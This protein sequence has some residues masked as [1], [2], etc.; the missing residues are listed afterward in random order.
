MVGLK[1]HCKLMKEVRMA[2]IFER[3]EKLMAALD[4]APQVLIVP[5]ND[6][7]PDAIASAVTLK[8]LIEEM[9]NLPVRIA[10]RGIIGRAENRALVR[11]L[12]HPL[13]CVDELDLADNPAV[14]LMDTQPGTGNNPLPLDY[15]P[16]VVID[17]HP[18]RELTAQA[19]FS[20]ISP[21]VGACSTILVEY[22]RA[23]EMNPSEKLATALFYGIQSDTRGL[24]RGS[25]PE[26]VEAYFYLQ[27]LIDVGA[28][29]KIMNAQVPQDY[30]KSLVRTLEAVR[31]Y[32]RKILFAHLGLSDYPDM[33]AEMADIL[34][35][36]EG[37]QW[38]I[39]VNTYNEM[40]VL[41]I[42]TRDEKGG[43]EELARA[44]VC[45]DG[46]AGGHDMMAGGQI[47]LVGEPPAD[48]ADKL[49]L[50]I[51]EYFNIPLEE[52]GQPLV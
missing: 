45:S 33:A 10:Y 31:I 21:H 2:A 12:E 38:V 17:H 1:F 26:D 6:P 34:L 8:H 5:H 49:R 37:S 35:R 14:I 47:P 29:G 51:L 3:L 41:S 16:A 36:L 32:R 22:L 18:L 15:V 52:P 50:R 11:Y 19:A 43:A 44:I 20:E 39:C 7:D 23:A 25:S 40:L 9:K 30:F 27:P 42:R 4:G 28:L 48:V 13:A 46:T 24:S